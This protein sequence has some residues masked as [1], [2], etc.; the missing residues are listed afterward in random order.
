MVISVPASF[1][2]NLIILFV[3]VGWVS[4]SSSVNA[5]YFY[6]IE[7]VLSNS[8]HAPGPLS[9]RK[10]SCRSIVFSPLHRIDQCKLI[11]R[12]QQP[13][14]SCRDLQR[15]IWTRNITAVQCSS[16]TNGSNDEDGL[17]PRTMR[18]AAPA[19][20]QSQPHDLLF[21]RLCTSSRRKVISRRSNSHSSHRDFSTSVRRWGPPRPPARLP[22]RPRKLNRVSEDD[23]FGILTNEAAD[24]KAQEEARLARQREDARLEEKRKAEQREM[25]IRQNILDIQQKLNDADSWLRSFRLKAKEER[26]KAREQG[27]IDYYNE[28]AWQRHYAAYVKPLASRIDRNEQLVNDLRSEVLYCV[29]TINYHI[30]WWKWRD[31]SIFQQ[32]KRA[33]IAEDDLKAGRLLDGVHAKMGEYLTDNLK[34]SQ[35]IQSKII[36]FGKSTYFSRSDPKHR[37][38]LDMWHPLEMADRVTANAHGFRDVNRIVIG[39]QY[40]PEVSYEIS[41]YDFKTIVARWSETNSDI[42]AHFKTY[43]DVPSLLKARKIYRRKDVRMEPF[44]EYLSSTAQGFAL[45]N[46]Y[47]ASDFGRD[48]ITLLR[49]F[50]AY[51]ERNN[52]LKVRVMYSIEDLTN[53]QPQ[54]SEL[55]AV[56]KEFEGRIYDFNRAAY[57]DLRALKFSFIASLLSSDKGGIDTRGLWKAIARMNELNALEDE[58]LQ[59]ERVFSEEL[60]NDKQTRRRDNALHQRE[61]RLLRAKQSKHQREEFSLSS[62]PLIG[63]F[64]SGYINAMES[65]P[66]VATDQ[67]RSKKLQSFQ[68]TS[69]DLVIR[70][71][72]RLRPARLNLIRRKLTV[73]ERPT[74]NLVRPNLGT[75][76]PINKGKLSMLT[77]YSSSRRMLRY[78]PGAI[79]ETESKVQD[80]KKTAKTSSRLPDDDRKVV[81][82]D[83]PKRILAKRKTAVRVGGKTSRL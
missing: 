55:I 17:C 9:M 63:K 66:Q 16:Y 41:T 34:Y 79:S 74:K 21:T 8:R 70:K 44:W 48:I 72:S 60:G 31:K 77:P 30:D 25:L 52:K 23:D 46:P 12:S 39:Q 15:F 65:P 33:L 78:R 2:S 83:D 5:S 53:L 26:Q 40:L 73:K 47:L 51:M 50:Y 49:P 68:E 22:P 37:A 69:K 38:I 59:K 10:A 43:Q 6:S 1:R 76:K 36:D 58:H 20:G 32:A 64:E 81:M 62:L 14:S 18:N 11:T 7:V 45:S 57:D 82:P 42:V 75:G 67:I 13:G 28:R 29:A 4:V 54:P 61:R 3:L 19:D 27:R 35:E 24:K 80:S 56:L 71:G